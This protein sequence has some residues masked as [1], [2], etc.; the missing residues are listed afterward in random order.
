MHDIGNNKAMKNMGGHQDIFQ[1]FKILIWGAS[2]E[3]V[4]KTKDMEAHRQV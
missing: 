3:P 1:Y 2:A 4:V